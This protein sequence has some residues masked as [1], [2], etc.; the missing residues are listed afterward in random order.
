MLALMLYVTRL[1]ACFIAS[2]TLLLHASFVAFCTHHSTYLLYGPVDHVK[3]TARH[4]IACCRHCVE[5]TAASPFADIAY[6]IGCT[7]V[8]RLNRVND[9]HRYREKIEQ[10]DRVSVVQ[11]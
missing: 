9:S 10:S 4:S 7:Q 3:H 6:S 11:D 2:D 1:Y 5:Y 8:L